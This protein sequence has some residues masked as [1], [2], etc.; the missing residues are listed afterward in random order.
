M[1]I[2]NQY[3]A[4]GEKFCLVFFSDVICNVHNLEV[5]ILK[6]NMELLF[7]L[8]FWYDKQEKFYF[9]IIGDL[10]ILCHCLGPNSI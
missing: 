2:L 7:M 6:Q 1:C 3:N 10:L 9:K 4:I 8:L 5:C